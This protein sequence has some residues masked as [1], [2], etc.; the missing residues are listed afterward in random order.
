MNNM[1]RSNVAAA[2]IKG[3]EEDLH[4]TGQQFNSLLSV[5]YVGFVLM[6]IPSNAFVNQLRRPSVY[7]S[8]CITSWGILSISTGQWTSDGTNTSCL[9]LDSYPP[10]RYRPEVRIHC[11]TFL[12]T[13]FDD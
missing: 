4:L 3:L 6:Q 10:C 5:L 9:N 2:R 7:L 1:N 13:Q 8:L 12:L 11:T